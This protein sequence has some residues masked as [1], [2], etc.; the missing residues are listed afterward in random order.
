MLHLRSDGGSPL[1]PLLLR[2]YGSAGTAPT[3]A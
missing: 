3:G 1:G 2:A